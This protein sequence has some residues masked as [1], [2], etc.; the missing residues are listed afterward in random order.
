MKKERKT[1]SRLATQGYQP[2]ESSAEG[3]LVGGFSELALNNCSCS[4]L[5]GTDIGV[6]NN[7]DCMV[8]TSTT[9]TSTS[10]PTCS[11]GC[12]RLI[13]DCDC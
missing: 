6:V 1:M 13:I 10:I 5:E 2:L 7:C 9:T 12:G 4:Y 11:C 3:K 8:V